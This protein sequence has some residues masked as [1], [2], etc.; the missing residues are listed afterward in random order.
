MSKRG[1]AVHVATTRRR[2]KDKVYETHLL[3]RTYRESGKVKHETLGNLS[4]LPPDVVELIRR[5]LQGETFVSV[6]TSFD[7]VR[8]LPHGH[9]VAVLGTLHRLGL[10]KVIA[11]RSSP[12]RDLVVALIVAR[13]LDARSKLATVRTLDVETATTTLGEELGLGRV[14]EDALYAAMDWLL[15]RQARIEDEL[16][17]RHLDHTLILYDVTSSYFEGRTCPL[18][19]RGHNRDGKK[20]KLQIVIGLLCNQDG[21]PVAVEVFDGNTGDPTTV[22][23][24]VEK[25][26][27]RFG[28]S[29]VVL[30]GDRGML[31][32]ARIRED[33]QPAE[34]LSWITALRAPA[35]Q[36]LARQGRVSLSLFDE[37][38]LAEITSPDFPGER[39]VVCRNPL[40]AIERTRKRQQ[41]LAATEAQ[42]EKIVTATRRARQP[43]RTAA[44]IGQRVGKVLNTYKVGKHFQIDI[45][46]TCFTYR[47]KEAQI[48]EEAALDG[49]YVV[50]TDVAAEE[51]DAEQTVTAYKSLSAVER[52]FRTMKTVNLR[53]RPIHHHL[54]KRVR[55]HVFLCMLS[56][57]VEWHMRRALAEI[58]F[59]DAEPEAAP[60]E[61][62][63]AA[64]QRSAAAVTKAAAK[65]TDN[66]LPVHSFPSLLDH[67]GTIVRNWVR[68]AGRQVTPFTMVTQPNP[69]QRRAFDLL[70]VP[71][72]K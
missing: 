7:C 9:V 66:G 60:R 40:L 36:A 37:K 65:H 71:V 10:E 43:L 6:E 3:R 67:L 27:Q 4:H 12:E 53:I 61:S 47:R 22:A 14:E 46:D 13:L 69:L 25:I 59:T 64:A 41:L 5:S 18:A 68:P 58:L 20:G 34:G 50:R 15:P 48:R 33:L 52:A 72:P 2:Y 57:Y 29:R 45:T 54:E 26:R 62:V 49:I 30:V 16:A 23:P 51:L 32:Q 42:L 11:S 63:V 21:C 56:Y 55:A 44:Q 8:S 38:D 39:L 28:L 17:R 70:G 1:G 19:K 31:T 35:I 24:Q